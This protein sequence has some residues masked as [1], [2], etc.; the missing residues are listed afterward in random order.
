MKGRLRVEIFAAMG[1]LLGAIW[2]IVRRV[3][4]TQRPPVAVVVPVGLHQGRVSSILADVGH[5][6]V[7]GDVFG[8]IVI[9]RERPESWVAHGGAIRKISRHDGH[10]LTI[11]GD[12]SA[13]LWDAQ[14]TVRW[15]RRHPDPLNDGVLVGD[16]LV[17]ATARGSVARL[18][19]D[20]PVWERRGA[21]GQAAFAVV[22][23]GD[24]VFS[25]G[26]D[27]RIVERDIELGSERR[28]WKGS[29]HWIG[30]LRWTPHGLVFGDGAGHLGVQ[31]DDT[32]Q[33]RY[34]LKGAAVSLAVQDDWIA[35]GGE[36]GEIEFSADARHQKFE[37]REPV[38]S[39]AFRGETLLSGGS[40]DGAVRIWR[41]K[42]GVEVGRLPPEP[43]PKEQR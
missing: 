3:D 39:L 11:S 37:T 1:L 2:V 9:W 33:V 16:A 17:V 20:G 40:K 10:L 5:P 42:D 12:G 15:R 32:F 21:H 18:G 43:E 35:L 13:A 30:V 19:P 41:V 29:V 8:R 28:Q 14:G 7:T 24:S 38:L 6:V 34:A 27:G 4:A 31:N 25:S 23:H 36:D 22:A 26:D